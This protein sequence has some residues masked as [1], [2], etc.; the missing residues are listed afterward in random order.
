MAAAPGI[1]SLARTPLI[2][3]VE[4]EVL[5]ANPDDVYLN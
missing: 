3:A 4:P 2:I 1:G 5:S